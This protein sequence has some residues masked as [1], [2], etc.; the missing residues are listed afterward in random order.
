MNR[1]VFDRVVPDLRGLGTRFLFGLEGAKLAFNI[2]NLIARR[3][4]RIADKPW[5]R[6]IGGRGVEGAR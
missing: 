6:M 5:R 2:G 1:S 3:I 4:A